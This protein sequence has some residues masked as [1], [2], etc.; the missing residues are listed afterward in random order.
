MVVNTVRRSVYRASADSVHSMEISD[1]RPTASP[2]RAPAKGPVVFAVVA[3][4]HS[5]QAPRSIHV[6]YK[7][8]GRV[9]G[10]RLLVASHLL[11][12]GAEELATR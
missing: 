9:S 10:H 7:A 11:L 3:F 2:K 12:I 8:D 5:T 6:L 1:F 4:P